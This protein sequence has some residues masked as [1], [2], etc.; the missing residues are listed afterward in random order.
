M[1]LRIAKW[2]LI[3]CIVNPALAATTELKVGIANQHYDSLRLENGKLVGNLAEPY[4]CVVD[5][6]AY[7]ISYYVLPQIRV[8]NL[9]QSGGLEVGIPLVHAPERDE[10]AM[11]AQPL[12]WPPFH[13][14]A[15]DDID[16]SGD[17]S[18]YTF[19]VVR[20]AARGGKEYLARNP[21][22][23]EVN[24]WSHALAMAQFGRADGAVIPA[25]VIKS[26]PPKRFEGLKKQDFGA[27]PLSMY[28][29]KQSA[30]AHEILRDL[31][32]SIELCLAKVD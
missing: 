12:L 22:F 26:L 29:S 18:G 2:L 1:D 31:N 8:L 24:E 28:V 27:I 14:Y 3:F 21:N 5:D 4:Q 11:F 23:I 20:S 9:L 15:K 7:S 10:Y 32:A 25:P 30:N 13:L 17:L 16:T 6:L 19:T